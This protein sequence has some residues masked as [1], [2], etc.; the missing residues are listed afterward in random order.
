[1]DSHS[2]VGGQL[3]TRDQFRGHTSFLTTKEFVTSGCRLRTSWH[4]FNSRPPVCPVGHTWTSS[5]DDSTLHS[6][7][8]PNGAPSKTAFFVT[9]RPTSADQNYIEEADQV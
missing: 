6:S 5:T 1:M 3:V 9:S 2:S 7:S 8:R 4:R